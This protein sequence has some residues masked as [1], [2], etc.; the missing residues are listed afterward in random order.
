MSD[1]EVITI[2]IIFYTGGFL[3]FKH[4]Y[5]NYVKVH[6]KNEFPKTASYNRFVELQQKAAIPMAIC[7]KTCCLY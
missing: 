5:I 2:L 7:L 3:N 4:F 1:S 6:L